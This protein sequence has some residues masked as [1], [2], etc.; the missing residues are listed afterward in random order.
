MDNADSKTA[1]E[2]HH[3]NYLKI[4]GWLLV[5]LVASIFG[6]TIHIM[7]VILITAFGIALVKAFMVAAYFMHLN[8]EKKYIWHLMFGCLGVLAVMYA[9]LIWDVQHHDGKNWVN[10]RKPPV[11]T[12]NEFEAQAAPAAAAPA[13]GGGDFE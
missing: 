1:H 13:A 11:I 8:V 10:S 2:G 9:I 5:L 7:A 6:P 4:Y 12:V 3:T